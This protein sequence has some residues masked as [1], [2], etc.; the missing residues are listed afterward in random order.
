MEE[1]FAKETSFKSGVKNR[2]SDRFINS[3]FI[4]EQLIV[5]YCKL[6]SNFDVNEVLY[7]VKMNYSSMCKFW[8][9]TN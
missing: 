8:Y 5:L 9:K 2:G 3:Y 4:I 6:R 7:S 1:R